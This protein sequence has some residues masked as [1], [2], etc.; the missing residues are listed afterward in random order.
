MKKV[1]V[2]EVSETFEGLE[3]G[4][5]FRHNDGT[6]YLTS[7]YAGEDGEDGF[8]LVNLN[9]EDV[10]HFSTGKLKNVFSDNRELFTRVYSVT[11]TD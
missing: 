2:N 7:V 9:G 4:Q 5:M 8:Q 11:L 3:V 1:L 10:Y 6:V